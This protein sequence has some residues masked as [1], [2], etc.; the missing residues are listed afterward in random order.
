MQQNKYVGK[1]TTKAQQNTFV[2]NPLTPNP[3]KFVVSHGQSEPA[4]TRFLFI[5]LFIIFIIINLL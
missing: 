1:H 3:I 4:P 2:E 5:Y